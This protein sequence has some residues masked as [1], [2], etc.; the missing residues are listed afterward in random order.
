M[1]KWV[2][3]LAA[4]LAALVIVMGMAACS[5]N[6]SNEDNV[7][8]NN[9]RANQQDAEKKTDAPKPKVKAPPKGWFKQVTL[10]P[11][12]TRE[13][14][15]LKVKAETTVP[16]KEEQYLTYIFWKNGQRTA[17]KREDTI[18]PKYYKKGD[19]VFAEVLFHH[20]DEIVGRGRS[21][22][23]FVENTAPKITKI[24][25]PN[26]EGPGTYTFTITASDHDGDRL[27][28]SLLPFQEGEELPDGLEIDSSTGSVTYIMSES[29]SPSTLK[30]VV[31]ADDNDG[32]IAK[33]SVSISFKSE[34][35]YREEEKENKNE[36]LE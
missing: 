28:F 26:I 21:D 18:P 10:T 23:L 17:E 32:G 30:F 20:Q 29:A 33:K 2:Q 15:A 3:W 14:N 5:G 6:D 36:S 24:D 4:M 25:I 35:R 13:G 16:L 11:H 22:S 34:T 9:T 12:K 7:N 27:T 8:T 31:S 19:V 1:N